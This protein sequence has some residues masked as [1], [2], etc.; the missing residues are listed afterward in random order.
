[1]QRCNHTRTV[2]SHNVLELARASTHSEVVRLGRHQRV[3]SSRLERLA[4]EKRV[5]PV[6]QRRVYAM[7]ANRTVPSA[8]VRESRLDDGS[9]S[10]MH[11]GESERVRE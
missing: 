4:A 10:R 7:G 5:R 6:G 11:A 8:I 1:M 3:P 9:V 2:R